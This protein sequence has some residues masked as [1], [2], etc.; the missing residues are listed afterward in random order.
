[1]RG[2]DDDPGAVCVG[3][4]RELRDRQELPGDVARPGDGEQD[5][6]ALI[7][8]VGDPRHGAGQGVRHLDVTVRPPLPGQEV[9]VVLDVEEEHLAVA[10][11]GGGQQVQR[12]GGV[13]DDDHGV[14]LARA[15]EPADPA[16]G[17]LVEGGADLR[18]PAGAAMD[19]AVQGQDLGHVVG[20][21]AQC[22]RARRH[23]EVDVARGPA[24]HEGDA[25][26]GTGDGQQWRDGVCA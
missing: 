4:I 9:R 11:D 8:G 5:D 2:V 26:A 14:V 16:S 24:V 22:R 3:E 13:P 19:A 23:I 17:V 20:D 12:V 6:G 18:R 10:R 1:L 21:H 7:Q 25:S 15:D